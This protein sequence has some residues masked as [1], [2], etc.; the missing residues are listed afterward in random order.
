MVGMRR[1]DRSLEKEAAIQLLSDCEW[2]VLSMVN[3]HIDH[4]LGLGA[5][6]AIPISF[7]VYKGSVYFHCA[8]KGHKI[9]NLRSDDRVCLT[10]VGFAQTDEPAYSVA[11]SSTVVFAKASEVID[12]ELKKE[13]L[14]ALCEKYV[15][16]QMGTF[17]DV[18]SRNMQ[19]TAVWQLE[20]EDASG[21]H[22]QFE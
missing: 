6:Y 4:P 17:P 12:E 18:Y 1:K 16:G 20:I 21:K 5:P 19:R 11:Y 22:R 7:V 10:A 3:A 14:F 15:P 2:A 13:A 8:H 9:E